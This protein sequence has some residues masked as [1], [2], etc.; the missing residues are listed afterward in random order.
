[1]QHNMLKKKL[2]AEEIVLSKNFKKL[3]WWGESL[4]Y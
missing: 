2:V 1:M 4:I 3:I